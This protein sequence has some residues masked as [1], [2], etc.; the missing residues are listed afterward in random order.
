MSAVSQSGENVNV[1]VRLKPRAGTDRV[2]GER[3]GAIHI[4]VSKPPVNDE[5]NEAL[6]GLLAKTLRHPRTRLELRGRRGRRK[7]VVVHG[8]SAVEVR[9]ALIDGG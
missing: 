8:A 9:R 4:E 5:A 2:V 3:D 1:S 6:L 7:H